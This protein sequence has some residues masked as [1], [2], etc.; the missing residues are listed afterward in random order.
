MS[1]T[2]PSE[3]MVPIASGP[4][5]NLL[6]WE[7][8]ID[9]ILR[10]NSDVDDKARKLVTLFPQMPVEGQVEAAH[11]IS[12]LLDDK[13][14]PEFSRYLTNSTTPEDVVDV[15]MSDVLNRP[16]SMKMP[17]LLDVASNPDHPQ[18]PIA[19]E[20]LG[21]YLEEDYGTNWSVWREKIADWL[22]TNPD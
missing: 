5:T 4:G 8:R 18:A 11:H 16:N 19:L 1:S 7:T 9:E 21:L 3:V 10:D 22:K 2:N 17:V 14:Y 15:L 13:D 12:N 20:T 6:D